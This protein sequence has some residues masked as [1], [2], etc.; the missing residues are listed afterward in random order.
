MC[1]KISLS[2]R[3]SLYKPLIKKRKQLSLLDKRE[4][5]KGE[6]VRTNTQA[7]VSNSSAGFASI[8]II[9][10]SQ[11]RNFNHTFKNIDRF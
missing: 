10:I 1:T 4:Y 7:K 5:P 11:E 2:K 6:G 8:Y 3:R 9:Y